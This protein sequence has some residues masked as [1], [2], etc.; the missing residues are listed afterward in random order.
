[1]HQFTT[2]FKVRSGRK[3]ITDVHMEKQ[4]Q[5]SSKCNKPLPVRIA[6]RMSADMLLIIDYAKAAYKDI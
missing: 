3:W 2:V 5:S 4:L 6:S 1:M